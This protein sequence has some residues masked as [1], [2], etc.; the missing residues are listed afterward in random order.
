M[1]YQKPPGINP[2]LHKDHTL[3]S[4]VLAGC[5]SVDVHTG[6]DHIA[7]VVRAVPD[8]CVV[9]SGLLLVLKK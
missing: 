6:G 5:E 8:Y 1:L 2:L 3:G 7:V 4:D 9:T